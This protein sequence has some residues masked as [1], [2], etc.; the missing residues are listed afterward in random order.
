MTAGR[1]ASSQLDILLSRP[2]FNRAG[3]LRRHST[4]YVPEEDET[5]INARG[6]WRG[7]FMAYRRPG[8]YS[9]AAQAFVAE[10]VI[11]ALQNNKLKL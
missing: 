5:R 7:E 11:G 8:H 3:F 9:A 1:P 10:A 4:E 6:L 2:D